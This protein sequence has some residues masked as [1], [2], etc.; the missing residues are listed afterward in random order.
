MIDA[1]PPSD[2]LRL[3]V[4]EGDLE[5]LDAHGEAWDRLAASLPTCQPMLTHAWIATYLEQQLAPGERWVALLSYAGDVLRGVLCAVLENRRVLGLR[6][7]RAQV[8]GHYHTD[9]GD[10]VLD[11]DHAEETAASLIEGLRRHVRR[12]AF[13][14]LGG[15]RDDSPTWSAL[16]AGPRGWSVARERLVEGSSFPIR[17]DYDSWHA[18]LSKNLRKD[19]KRFANRIKKSD[20]GEMRVEF[21]E[22]DD[23][24]PEQLDALM[25]V[26]ASGWKA[27]E[28]AALATDPSREKKYRALVERFAARGML[29][30][31]RLELGERVAAIH[32]AVR[33]G[34]GLMLLRQGLEQEFARFG[35]GNLLIREAVRREFERGE[36]GEFNLVTDYPWCRRWRMRLRPYDRVHVA[37]RRPLGWLAGILPIRA[38]AFVRRL[39]GVKS[40]WR[41]IRKPPDAAET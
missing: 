20:L 27:S 17:G 19:L 12:L 14:E 41:R 10:L 15:V 32:M 34:R 13:L 28:G 4:I 30:F 39:P 22:G 3:V 29:E 1:P 23:A 26:E 21:V 33:M 16:A 24:S 7:V 8:P 2:P 11:P 5:A 36:G 35:A 37:R 25:A 6:R 40:L 9:A 18:G 31:H 38:K